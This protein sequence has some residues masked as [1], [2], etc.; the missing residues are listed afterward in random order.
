M[1][2]SE[3]REMNKKK[4][5]FRPVTFLLIILVLGMILYPRQISD[6]E[7]NLYI[8]SYFKTVGLALGAG[9]IGAFLG[10]FLAYI[11]FQKIRFLEIIIDEYVDIMRGTP[12]ILQLYIFSLVIFAS[13]KGD[14][15]FIAMVALGLN[16]AAYVTEIVRSGIESIDK[17][18]LEAA[19]AIGMPFRMAMNEIVIPQAIKNVL[20]ALV[21][22]FIVL[23]K[24]TSI[25]GVIS[26]VDITM[27]SKSLQATYYRP[28]PLFFTGL[29]YYAS[30]KLF[31]YLSKVFEGRL[32]AND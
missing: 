23:F 10:I 16:S 17:G 3:R 25:V 11:K 9:L 30:V 8:L 4:S 32:K 27:N 5:I 28:E 20:P 6:K 24:E 7:R 14:N 12:M 29:V 18:Q 22:E 31:S 15:Y 2:K 19:R 13:W 1:I 21:N 26:V